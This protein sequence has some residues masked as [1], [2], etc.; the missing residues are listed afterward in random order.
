MADSNPSIIDP[1]LASYCGA[2]AGRYVCP[3]FVSE[4]KP[5]FGVPA[6][7]MW[8]L[9]SRN[10][11]EGC[12]RTGLEFPAAVRRNYAESGYD[13]GHCCP[14]EDM[15]YDAAAMSATFC[16]ENQMPQTPNLNR[17][18]WKALEMSCRR[19]A[20]QADLVIIAGPAYQNAEH[21]QLASLIMVPEQCF[22]IVI[23]R[24]GGTAAGY[25]FNNR[26]GLCQAIAP[27]ML[28]AVDLRPYRLALAA[29]FQQT[30]LTFSINEKELPV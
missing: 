19:Q 11:R 3:E 16:A 10:L 13:I 9:T 18:L 24:T 26:P 23:D 25:R 14:A 2:D 1:V 5:G 7:V 27:D 30:G 4:P 12:S 17:G 15:A 28:E 22:K 20:A 6:W 29:I 8:R 21:R